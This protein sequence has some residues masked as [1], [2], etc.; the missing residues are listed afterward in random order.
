MCQHKLDLLPF[1]VVLI[2]KI[3]GIVQNACSET[4]GKDKSPLH[5]GEHFI[6]I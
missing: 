3:V 1:F 4:T 5:C 2:E 6:P